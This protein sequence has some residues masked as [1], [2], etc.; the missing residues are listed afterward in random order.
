MGKRSRTIG[1]KAILAI[2]EDLGVLKLLPSIDAKTRRGAYN[3][4]ASFRGG[5]GGVRWGQNQI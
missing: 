4:T 5:L 1:Q 2:G 3:T